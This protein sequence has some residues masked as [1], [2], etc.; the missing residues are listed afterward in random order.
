MESSLPFRGPAVDDVKKD[1][2]K[3]VPWS[4]PHT[5]R[6]RAEVRPLPLSGDFFLGGGLNPNGG[7]S[8]IEDSEKE[9]W[10]SRVDEVILLKTKNVSF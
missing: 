8:E 2:T 5:P 3:I 4:R 6:G 10:G 7:S 1:V 9:T